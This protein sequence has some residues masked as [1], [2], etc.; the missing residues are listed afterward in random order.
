MRKLH[1]HTNN[2]LVTRRTAITGLAASAG[3][4]GSSLL[5]GCGAPQNQKPDSAVQD[6]VQSARDKLAWWQDTI[7]YEAYPKSFLDTVGQGTGTIAGVTSKLDYLA[8]LG[9]GAIWLTPVYKSPMKD[10]GYDVSDYYQIDPSFGTMADMEQLIAEAGGRNIRIVMDLVMNHTS[11][12]NEWFIE[13]SSS[14]DNPKADWYI[15]RDAKEDGSAPNNWRSLF[16]GS[17]WTWNDN[18]QQ[19]YLHTFG[20]FQPDLNWECTEMREELFRMARF[21]LKKGLGGFRIDAVT[22]IKKP[23]DFSDGE[24]DAADGLVS[25]HTATANTKGI[26]DLLREFKTKVMDGSDAFTVAEAG[27]VNANELGDWV[28]KNGVFDM[29]IQF[30]HLDALEGDAYSQFEPGNGKLTDF[31]GA[32][33]AS[34]EA[35]AADG[36]YCI[37]F[38]NHDQPRSVNHILP[39]AKDKPAGAKMLGTL[40]M[41]LRGTPFLYEGEELGYANIAWDSID[42]YDDVTTY[43]LYAE[44]LEAGKTEEEALAFAQFYSRDNARTPMQWDASKNAGFTTGKPWLP[45]HDDYETCNVDV[46]EQDP[47]SVLPWYLSLRQLR[48]DLPVLEVGD[49]HELMAD[50]EEVFAYERCYGADKAVILANFTESQVTFD[51]KLVEGMELATSTHESSVAGTLQPLEAVV[52]RT[53]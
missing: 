14:K 49:Y 7:V 6:D 41:T 48:E 47:E 17:A 15:W 37:Y 40:L 42:D 13:S 11:N 46:Q 32:I 18:R 38:E 45:V 30:S 23:A 35:T 51:K 19:Y 20:D 50:S 26:L 8:S 9:V 12:E 52:Y 43:T 5:T 25:I 28:G 1:A 27:G 2:V 29:L 22:Y 16:G 44:A 39:R 33:T 4:V 10:N 21:W 31:K 36:W 53:A 34:Q 3:L 24:P